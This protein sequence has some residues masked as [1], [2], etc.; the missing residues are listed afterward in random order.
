MSLDENQSDTI[1]DESLEDKPIQQGPMTQSH[2]RT[3][4]KIN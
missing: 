4:I 1:I 3:L 2:T